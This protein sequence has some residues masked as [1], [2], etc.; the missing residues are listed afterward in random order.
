[1]CPQGCAFQAEEENEKVLEVSGNTC[2]RGKKY[3]IQEITAPMRNIATSVKVENG[4]LPLAS[5]RLTGSI[6]KSKI[7][8]A[9]DE[10]RKICVKA[11]VK[12]GDI[13]IENL[14]E[15]GESVIIT[16]TIHKI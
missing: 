8:R 13:V 10:I 6:P 7:F 5:V 14:L 16:K 1:M 11:P 15:T 4:E 9:M 3:A 12:T 2:P